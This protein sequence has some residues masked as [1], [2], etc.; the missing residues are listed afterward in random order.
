M[1]SQVPIL[2]SKNSL[3]K[4]QAA[5]DFKTN[6]LA[7]LESM[8]ISMISAGSGHRQLPTMKSGKSTSL[9]NDQGQLIFPVNT[10]PGNDVITVEELKKI[11]IHLGHCIEFTLKNMLKAAKIAAPQEMIT[12]MLSQRSCSGQVNRVT[13]PK[14]SSWI[15]KFNGEIV[16]LDVAYPF[17]GS[18]AQ[19]KPATKTFGLPALM[20]VC[21]LARFCSCSLSPT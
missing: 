20:M 4:T 6:E 5:I 3:G 15:A 12:R 9:S 14:I 16:G 11:H 10:D 1:E 21:C 17:T 19:K 7:I 13:P 2:I 8:A 18:R